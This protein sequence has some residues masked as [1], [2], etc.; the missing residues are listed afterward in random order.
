MTT[1][2]RARSVLAGAPHVVALLITAPLFATLPQQSFAV[3]SSENA[4][5]AGAAKVDITPPVSALFSGD[6]IRDHL[7]V[8][9]IVVDNGHTCVALVS[10]DQANLTKDMV[11]KGVAGASAAIHCPAENF[12]VSATHTHSGGVG[13][14]DAQT[15]PSHDELAAAIVQSVER[16]HAQMRPASIG[17]GTT[18]VYLNVN[19]D[20]YEHDKWY[21][22]PNPAGP[23]DKTLAVIAF[24]GA[25][26]YPIAY[27]FDYAMHPIN[28]YLSGVISG[29]FPGQA[30]RYLEQRYAGGTVALFGQGASGDVFPLL[31]GPMQ[32]LLGR[33]TRTAGFDD[34]RFGADD[35]W[36][37]GSMMKN[38]NDEQVAQMRTPIRPEERSA[39][40]EA[41]AQDGALVA[42][43]G[44]L[45]GESVID[46]FKHDMGTSIDRGVLWSGQERLTCPGRDRI[47]STAREGARPAYKDIDPVSLTVGLIRLGDIYIASID[48]EV[49]TNIWTHVKRDVPVSKLMMVGLAGGQA[50]SGYIYSDD[51]GSHLTFEVIGSHLKPGCAENKIV[52][53]VRTLINSANSLPSR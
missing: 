46:V 50:N 3:G 25:D 42:A 11:S 12:L 1:Q 33:R 6:S 34:E 18:S 5:R 51:A 41:I 23:A 15:L 43:E 52:D 53:A 35:P 37:V 27:Y 16:A 40:E 19:R 39:Y 36:K 7:Y 20:L 30:S 29:D 17:F 45:L 38:S 2:L 13:I 47:D 28:F 10:L 8:R 21:Q 49:Y 9:A 31:T 48:G 26:H 22:G 32:K 44:T 4:F 24:I 14:L